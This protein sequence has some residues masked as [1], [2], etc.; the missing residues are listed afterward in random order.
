MKFYLYTESMKD[1]D[2]VPIEEPLKSYEASD[3]HEAI[4]ACIAE[5]PSWMNPKLEEHVEARGW[6]CISICLDGKVII[7]ELDRMGLVDI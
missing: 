3:I 1:E 7:I 4:R 6:A 2:N 5:I